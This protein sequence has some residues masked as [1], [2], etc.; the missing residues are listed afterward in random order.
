MQHVATGAAAAKFSDL[1][2]SAHTGAFFD[3]AATVMS[4]CRQPFIAV[5]DDDQL[6]VTDQPSAGIHHHPIARSQHWLA[7]LAGNRYALAGAIA[8]CITGNDFTLRWP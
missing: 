8:S 1:L 7:R 6:T 5:F 3:Q 4:I 2:A